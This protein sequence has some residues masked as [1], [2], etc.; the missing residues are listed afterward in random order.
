MSASRNSNGVMITYVS[1]DNA[2]SAKSG[3]VTRIKHSLDSAPCRICVHGSVN[4]PLL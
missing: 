4:R 3:D 2:S 1:V